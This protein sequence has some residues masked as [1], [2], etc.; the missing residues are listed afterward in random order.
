MNISDGIDIAIVEI[1]G[2]AGDIESLPFLEAIRQLRFDLGK[3]NV[4]YVHLT[5]LPY[6][7]TAHELK[8][9]PTQHSVKDLREIGIQP[10]VSCSAG[11]IERYPKRRRTRSPSSVMSRKDSVIAVPDVECIYEVPLLFHSQGLDD[12]I[13][14]M[15]NIWTGA[16][17][18]EPW[19]KIVR[20]EQEP[21]TRGL[22]R[23]CR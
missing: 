11:P 8:T 17:K 13:L 1:G 9:K 2:T 16:P 7:A 4:L 22:Y 18:L 5:L 20:E 6:I 14:E 15:L 23:D 21:Q 3:E 12:N 19:E 10:D